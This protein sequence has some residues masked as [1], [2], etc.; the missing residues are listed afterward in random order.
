MLRIAVNLDRELEAALAGVL[1]A[2]LDGSTDAEVVWQPND[3][4][5]RG[6][7]DLCSLIVRA[8]VDDDY[9]EPGICGAD[10]GDHAGDRRLLVQGGHDRDPTQRR[11]PGI[12]LLRAGSHDLLAFH[13][14]ERT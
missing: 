13:F 14:F 4:G 7:G 11:H 10:L 12:D 1:D 6:G 2:C 9:R 3:V 5:A 8:V